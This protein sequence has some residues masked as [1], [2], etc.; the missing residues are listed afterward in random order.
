MPLLFLEMDRTEDRP[1]TEGFADAGEPLKVRISCPATDSD[2]QETD[3]DYGVLDWL[4]SAQIQTDP[5][6]DSIHLSIRFGPNNE[7]RSLTISQIEDGVFYV[8]TSRSVKSDG[9]LQ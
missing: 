6:N 3:D 2:M 4:R 9:G 7:S 5:E 8:N 1:Q